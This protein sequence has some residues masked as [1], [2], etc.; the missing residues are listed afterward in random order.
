MRLWKA[1]IPDEP[2]ISDSPRFG[3]PQHLPPV[4][5]SWCIISIFVNGFIASVEALAMYHPAPLLIGVMF[6][7]FPLYM[8]FFWS[9]VASTAADSN[10][11][12]SNDTPLSLNLNIGTQWLGIAVCVGSTFML[13]LTSA[14][15]WFEL[16]AV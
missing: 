14:I 7:L 1:L 6:S 3:F 13:C 4:V 2:F 10:Q 5:K 9:D 15:I 12:V 11:R 8:I 16:I